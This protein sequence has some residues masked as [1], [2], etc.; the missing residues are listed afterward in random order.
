MRFPAEPFSARRSRRRFLTTTSLAAAA[1]WASRAEGRVLANPS[2]PAD[3]F[4]LGVASGDPTPEGVVLWTR[5]A[6]RPLEADG[7]MPAE[8]VEVSWEIADDEGFTKGV[9]RGTVTA[10]PDWA[11]SIHVEPTG[12]APARWYF[13]RFHAGAATSPVG[14]TRTTPAAGT[15]PERL[16]FAFASCQNWEEGLYTAY[17]AMARAELDLILHL[18]DYIYEYPAREG[19]VRRHGPPTDSLAGFRIRH[20]LYKTDPLLQA[21]HAACPWLVTWDDHE[22]EDN[23]ASA[24]PHSA[25]ETPE[26]LLERRSWASRAYWEQMPLRAASLPDGPDMKLYRRSDWG[27][28]AEFFVLDT[29][30]YRTDQPCGDGNKPPCGEEMRDDATLTGSEQEAWLLEGFRASPARW[31][32]LAQ[33]VM[34]ARI[35]RRAGPGEAYSMDQWPGYEQQRRRILRA[36]AD[37]P[38]ANPLVLTG[39]IHSHWANDLLVDFDGGPS[40]KVGAELVGTSISSGG[41]GT[42]TPADLAAILAEN[43]C[44]RF[45]SQQRGYVRCEVTPE[46]A[47]ADFEVVDFVDKPGGTVSTAASFRI[48]NGRPGL[49]PA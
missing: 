45:H 34:M 5:L 46:V 1:V 24:T 3:P 49:V 26:Q 48:E 17:G 38:E 43:P 7:G 36:F 9:R 42:T 13:Y 21:A 31:N 8:A 15:M 40:R 18:G 11:H 39:D 28:L 41:N 44:L 37:R 27:T 32:V 12:L 10:T 29:R 35:D 19:R 22:V 25:T 14:R 47:R 23:Y 16:A 6:P 33:Q 20:A 4:A 2:F 30:Q